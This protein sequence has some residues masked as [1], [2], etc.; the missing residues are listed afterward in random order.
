MILSLRQ[1]IFF[2]IYTKRNDSLIVELEYSFCVTLISL[3]PCW[4]LGIN[5][6]G[7]YVILEIRIIKVF[8]ILKCILCAYANLPNSRE[9]YDRLVLVYLFNFRKIPLTGKYQDLGQICDETVNLQLRSLLN[10]VKMQSKF[11]WHLEY[12]EK[13]RIK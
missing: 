11:S 3:R 4:P 5:S 12:K 1:K 10:Q 9:S 7:S 6:T 8:Q 13:K 2:D